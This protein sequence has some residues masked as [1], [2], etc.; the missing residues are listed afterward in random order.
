M[1]WYGGCWVTWKPTSGRP[2][3]SGTIVAVGLTVAI[4]WARDLNLLALGDATAAHLGLNVRR[5][6]MLFFAVASLM[7]GATVAACG[8]I[9]F[10]GLIVPHAVRLLVGP[11]HR[12][13]VPAAALAA[14]RS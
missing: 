10:V 5:S 3:R 11:D 4:L 6:R 12:R 2:W 1:A 9:G 8:I 13:L 7:T 14:R